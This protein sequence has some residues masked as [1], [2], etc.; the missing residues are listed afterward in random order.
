MWCEGLDGT[1][2][3]SREADSVVVLDDSDEGYTP[4]KPPAKK[5]KKSAF[6]ERKHAIQT[7]FN[8]IQYKL[9]AEALYSKQH[10]S[11]D[12]PAK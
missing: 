1:Q 2:E 3:R 12:E 10:T 6:E 11:L 7:T 9:W 4:G 5:D 8:M